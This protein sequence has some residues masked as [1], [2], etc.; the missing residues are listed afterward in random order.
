MCKLQS[1]WQLGCGE[2]IISLGCTKFAGNFLTFL[3]TMNIGYMC[4][5]IAFGWNFFETNFTLKLL[6][7]MNSWNMGRQIRFCGKFWWTLFTLEFFL[8]YPL[9]LMNAD[10]MFIILFFMVNSMK[11]ISHF[12]FFFSWTIN[13]CVSIS[14]FREK[15]LEQ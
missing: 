6:F 2:K 13:V 3:S 10:L 7:F 11:Q 1:F 9:L 8:E 14:F 5:Q 15:L 4:N 12:I